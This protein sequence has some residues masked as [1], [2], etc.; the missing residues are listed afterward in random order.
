MQTFIISYDSQ[1]H[2]LN[3]C[4][5]YLIPLRTISVNWKQSYSSLSEELDFSDSEILGNFVY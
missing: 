3:I 5:F 1:P 2:I 4:K